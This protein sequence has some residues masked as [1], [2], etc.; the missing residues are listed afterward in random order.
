MIIIVGRRHLKRVDLL[1]NSRIRMEMKKGVLVE[2]DLVGGGDII[3]E[4]CTIDKMRPSGGR[5]VDEVNGKPR[6]DGGASRCLECGSDIKGRDS[7]I[8]L[9]VAEGCDPTGG[10]LVGPIGRLPPPPPRIRD[11]GNK[12]ANQRE[13]GDLVDINLV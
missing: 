12:L 11:R 5:C 3:F 6:E 10:G 8:G 4:R 2:L 9:L 7:P 13:A 1:R